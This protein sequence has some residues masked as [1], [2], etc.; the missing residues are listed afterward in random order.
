MHTSSESNS[1]NEYSQQKKESTSSKICGEKKLP[2]Q[3]SIRSLL[4]RKQTYKPNNPKKIMLDEQLSR[5]IVVQFLPLN[6]VDAPEMIKLLNM[7][8]SRYVPPNRKKLTT[9][10]IPKLYKEIEIKIVAILKD[11]DHVSLTSDCWSS[12]ALESYITV[13]C[14]F[15]YDNELKNVVLSCSKIDSHTTENMA[16]VVS[17][18]LLKFE[19]DK[20]KVVSLTTDNANAAL[21]IGTKLGIPNI[22]CFAHKINLT[23]SDCLFPSKMKLEKYA[24]FFE[25]LQP[26]YNVIDIV[27]K[28]V[29]HFHC[30]VQA[31]EA[32]RKELKMQNEEDLVLIQDCKTRW[33]SSFLMLKRFHNIAAAVT[34]VVFRLGI[35]LPTISYN[36]MLLINEIILCLEPFKTATD[37]ISGSQYVT[38]SLLIPLTTGILTELEQLKVT[39]D[40]GSAF[41]KFLINRTKER[42]LP[43]EDE[44]LCSIATILDPRF[45]NFAFFD[46]TKVTCHILALQDLIRKKRHLIQVDSDPALAEKEVTGDQLQG[47]LFSFV[48]NRI[49]EKPRPARNDGLLNEYLN[50]A[51]VTK[52]TED[53]L[54]KF[55][56]MDFWCNKRQPSLLTD[57]AKKY[58]IPCG[59][60]VAS[61]KIFSSTGYLIDDRRT[62]LSNVNVNILITFIKNN[63]W[64]TSQ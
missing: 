33:N 37:R 53:E 56:I 7:L 21:G 49:K 48:K 22:G 44:K 36:D 16:N 19:I 34:A 43:Y 10:L 14:H 62:S 51:I 52:N 18:I 4:K 61:E 3:Q 41:R 45:K 31:T 8:D 38:I 35:N 60:S 50:E 29:T 17:E 15:I 54:Y 1:E 30:S 20:E 12:R 26:V 59:S 9:V 64:I 57:I 5:M 58:L 24:T 28:I 46:D 40:A 11:V 47:G 2:L 13:T 6:L 25:T 39:S 27:K 32:L 23:V 63:I 55:N 42:L